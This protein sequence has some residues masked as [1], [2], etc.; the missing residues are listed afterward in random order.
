MKSI[1]SVKTVLNVLHVSS[2]YKCLNFYIDFTLKQKI[3]FALR[4]YIYRCTINMSPNVLVK[5]YVENN[6]CIRIRFCAPL[7]YVSIYYYN[8][9]FIHKIRFHQGFYIA[10]LWDFLVAFLYIVLGYNH[11][12]LFNLFR[13]YLYSYLKNV[14]NAIHQ[15]N[16]TCWWNAELT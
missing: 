15:E 10:R 16:K 4:K 7:Y 8:I 6:M 3:L 5:Y 14:H 13:I 11:S 9:T 12:C 2:L 1:L